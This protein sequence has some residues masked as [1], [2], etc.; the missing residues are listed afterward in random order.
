M[1]RKFLPKIKIKKSNPQPVWGGG[2]ESSGEKGSK[3]KERERESEA[4]RE[5]AKE[6]ENKRMNEKAN[7]WL[8]LGD[9]I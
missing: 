7:G 4:E 3:C 1:R 6:L 5:R 2:E 9:F 8:K